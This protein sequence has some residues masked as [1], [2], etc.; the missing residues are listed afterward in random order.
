MKMK[1]FESVDEYIRGFPR[2]TQKQLRTLRA[3]I[4]KLAPEANETF[5]YGIP[6][7]KLKGNLVHF[8]GYETHIGF[9][10]TSSPV[11]VFAKELAKYETSK[12]TIRFPIDKPLPLPLIRKIVRYRLKESLGKTKP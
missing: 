3:E 6:T 7:F 1:R 11:K 8:A 5:S 4:R 10:P 9:Y 12:G 2:A